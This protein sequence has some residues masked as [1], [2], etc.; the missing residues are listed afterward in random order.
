MFC[1][2]FCKLKRSS[3]GFE[4]IAHTTGGDA[5]L[6]RRILARDTVYQHQASGIARWAYPHPRQSTQRIKCIL[7]NGF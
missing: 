2:Y 1:S 3:N 6:L 7:R 5:G 4:R